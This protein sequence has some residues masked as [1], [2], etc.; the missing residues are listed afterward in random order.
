M[1]DNAGP[2][3]DEL[4]AALKE[5]SRE[6]VLE[7][8]TNITVSLAMSVALLDTEGMP[9]LFSTKK[10]SEMFLDL[11]QKAMNQREGEMSSATQR[12]ASRRVFRNFRGSVE[13]FLR[14]PRSKG[15]R[16]ST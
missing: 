10:N 12:E 11:L 14:T 7:A 16:D 6:E 4:L 13:G 3:S 9:R 8:L 5:H 1:E 2:T 15:N